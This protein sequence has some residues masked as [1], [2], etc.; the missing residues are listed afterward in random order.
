MLAN[1]VRYRFTQR[2]TVPARS[3]YAW[4]TDYKTSDLS[5]MNEKGH[6]SIRKITNDTLILRETVNQNGTMITKTK[7]VR[8][9]PNTLSWY[10]VHMSGPNK[11]STFLYE[12]SPESKNQSKLT[13]TGLLLVYNRVRLRRQKIRQ[14]ANKEKR[15]DS[16]AWKLLARAMAKDLG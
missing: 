2:F 14:I 11:H 5:L 7:L 1:S 8:L 3:A 10:N 6:R 12:I 15:S 13:F 4:C 9:N 16:N